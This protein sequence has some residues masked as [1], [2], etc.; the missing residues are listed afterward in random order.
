MPVHKII[1]T[2]YKKLA[3]LGKLL[4]AFVYLREFHISFFLFVLFIFDT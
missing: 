3:S 1:L 4:F 2:N